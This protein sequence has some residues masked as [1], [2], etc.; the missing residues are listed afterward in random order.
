MQSRNLR[1][2]DGRVHQWRDGAAVILVMAVLVL[3]ILMVLVMVLI[4]GCG[5][6]AMCQSFGCQLVDK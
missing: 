5:F 3:V 1:R 6:A 2:M 4:R